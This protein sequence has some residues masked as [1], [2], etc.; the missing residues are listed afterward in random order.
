MDIEVRTCASVEELRD[1]LN[2][3]NHYFGHESQLEDAERFAQWIE[4]DRMHAAFDGGRIVGGAGAF[5]L[6]N[7]G[8]GRRDGSCRRRHR[9]RASCQRIAAAASSRR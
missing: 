1:G 5:T 9:R 7:V 4:V 2:A 6:P 3:I 8:S